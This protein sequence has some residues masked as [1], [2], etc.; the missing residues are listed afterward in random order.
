LVRPVQGK[1]WARELAL[2]IRR[3]KGEQVGECLICSSGLVAA[4]RP[5]TLPGAGSLASRA[6]CQVPPMRPV[7]PVPYG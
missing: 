6:C 7:K 4:R 3:V 2:K 5:R 1:R